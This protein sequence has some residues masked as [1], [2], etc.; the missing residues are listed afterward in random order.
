M[1]TFILK[2]LSNKHPGFTL[3]PVTERPLPYHMLKDGPLTPDGVSDVPLVSTC[4]AVQA[5][6]SPATLQLPDREIPEAVAEA[7]FCAYIQFGYIFQVNCPTSR[8]LV[9]K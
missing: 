3:H 8:Q 2:P 7:S 9:L 1:S 6:S 4:I 5:T